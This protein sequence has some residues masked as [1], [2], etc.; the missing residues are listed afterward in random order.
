MKLLLILLF[1][2]VFGSLMTFIV[3]NVSNNLN[4]PDYV[5]N[6]IKYT[7]LFRLSSVSIKPENNSCEKNIGS[8]VGYILGS[9]LKSNSNQ[10]LNKISERCSGNICQI[11]H[12]TC[13]PWQTDSCGSTTLSFK[14]GREGKIDADSFSCLQIP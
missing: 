10:Y 6:D 1:G 9:I 12:S 11:T 7:E 2:G 8:E 14:T 5:A 4:E 3:I 13:A